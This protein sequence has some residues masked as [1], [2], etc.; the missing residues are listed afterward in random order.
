MC[1]TSLDIINLFLKWDDFP[2][3]CCRSRSR[4]KLSAN[5]EMRGDQEQKGIV[6]R[7]TENA[8]RL[9]VKEKKEHGMEVE[10]DCEKEREG[11]REKKIIRERKSEDGDERRNK[12]PRGE[13]ALS[14]SQS[15]EWQSAARLVTFKRAARGLTSDWASDYSILMSDRPV[16]FGSKQLRR[17]RCR[18]KMHTDDLGEISIIE[19]V[20]PGVFHC[21]SS[22]LSEW[23]CER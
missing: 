2:V 14:K 5:E 17:L 8:D 9:K 22:V 4:L 10:A 19:P 23:N 21:F 3:A 12:R 15:K 11:E 16:S 20:I 18:I 13:V 6:P 1:F 7:L